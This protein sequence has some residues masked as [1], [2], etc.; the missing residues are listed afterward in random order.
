MGKT[1]SLINM[2]RPYL[3]HSWHRIDLVSIIAFWIAFLLAITGRETNEHRHV[4]IFQALSTLR[5]TRLLLIT[6]GTS[7]ILHSLKRAG[8]LLFKVAFFAFFA[9]YLL[10]IIGVKS[11]DGSF[12][13]SCQLTDPANAT[14][15]IDLQQACGGF[16]D[17][18]TLEEVGFLGLNGESVGKPKGYICPVGQ[19]CSVNDS[20]DLGQGNFDNIFTAALQ[21]VIFASANGWSPIMYALMD[22]DYYA[23]ALFP[24][25]SLVILNLWLVSLLIAILVNTFRAIRSEDGSAFGSHASEVKTAA[26]RVAPRFGS[27][28]RYSNWLSIA[29]ISASLIVFAWEPTQMS[30][31]SHRA[32]TWTQIAITVLLD[33]EIVIRISAYLPRPVDFF[34]PAHNVFDLFLA[35]VTTALCVPAIQETEAGN[36]LMAF[37]LMRFYRVILVVPR[38]RP[39]LFSIFGNWSSIGSTVLFLLILTFAATLFTT[40][41]L[42]GDLDASSGD[43]ITW[44][45]GFNAFLG[46]YQVRC[47]RTARQYHGLTS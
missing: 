12:H 45:N 17:P 34:S 27:I 28:V 32:L 36:W 41:L 26:P 40:R 31:S 11:F 19:T 44:S 24:I 47:R 37:F 16:I 3:R 23:S 43:L 46:M 20:A 39:L 2:G 30:A 21:L 14:H 33:V 25:A 38:M 18:T 15:T 5:V 9:L 6:S 35:I 8:P 42:Q 13:R 1:R 10:S 29:L 7:T 4:F 22:S